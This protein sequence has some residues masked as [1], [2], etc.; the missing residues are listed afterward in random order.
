MIGATTLLMA[1]LLADNTTAPPA[2]PCGRRLA[3][4]FVIDVDLVNGVIHPP[5]NRTYPGM[6]VI[7]C[8]TAYDAR[9]R[10]SVGTT[11]TP[12]LPPPDLTA[13]LPKPEKTAATTPAARATPPP[14]P[15]LNDIQNAVT[16]ASNNQQAAIDAIS[17]IRGLLNAIT[18]KI[19]LPLDYSKRDTERL[20]TSV[21]TLSNLQTQIDKWESQLQTFTVPGDAAT[22]Q[23]IQSSIKPLKDVAATDAK[24][25][26]AAQI[27]AAQLAGATN[28]PV[29]QVSPGSDTKVVITV[30]GTG[31]VA[32]PADNP[33]DPPALTDGSSV[34][35]VSTTI[36]V[37]SLTYV[38]VSPGLA[39]TE[40]RDR[41]YS[42]AP[43][44]LGT[45][46]ITGRDTS[47]TVGMLFFGHY[48]CGADIREVQPWDTSRPCWAANLLPTFTVGL[49]LSRNPAENFFIGLLW[50][51]V[52]A[53]SFT[54][55]AHLGYVNRLREDFVE[56]AA[57]PP[58]PGGFRIEDATE[59]RWVIGQFAGI[60]ISDALF[61]SAIQKLS[62]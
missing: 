7:I 33:T 20:A 44:E 43:N 11:E 62:Q 1:A 25:I 47:G 15:T 49:P 4:R 18:G 26:K 3:N 12:L 32:T 23:A 54:Y 52:P 21:G 10:L 6:T 46:T 51:P 42:L 40:V 37:R 27:G 22:V 59:R 39:F 8:V 5:S 60:A 50:Q 61:V 56:G 9:Y 28:R 36:E 19:A 16:A 14:Q 2:D 30:K 38:R 58:V 53:I 31:L 17:A 24:W 13:A 57:P 29:F 34:D 45:S 55:G 41:N 35:L 48:W